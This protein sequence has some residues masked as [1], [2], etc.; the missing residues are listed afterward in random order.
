MSESCLC[1]WLSVCCVF[2]LRCVFVSLWF[3]WLFFCV[4]CV[5]GMCVCCVVWLCVFVLSVHA[6]GS[7]EPACLTLWV[8]FGVAFVTCVLFCC[9]VDCF[10][11]CLLLLLV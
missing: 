3:V 4:V 5:V 11:L 1:E 7:S 2:L 9:C 10:V 6:C 8:V